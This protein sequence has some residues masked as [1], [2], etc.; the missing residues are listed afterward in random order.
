MSWVWC[1]DK[2]RCALVHAPIRYVRLEGQ[3]EH[4]RPNDLEKLLRP[5]LDRSYF[6]LNLAE[7]AAAAKQHPWVDKVQVERIWPDVIEVKVSEKVPYLRWGERDLFSPQ[8]EKFTPAAYGGAKEDMSSFANLPRLDGPPGH[9][10]LLF[11]A[12]CQMAEAL[13]PLHFKIRKLEVDARR[14]WQLTLESEGQPASDMVIVLGRQKPQ[15]V[16]ARVAQ[17][18]GSLTVR[19]R[20]RIERLDA[21]YKHGFAVRLRQSGSDGK[22]NP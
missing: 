16:F 1:R 5:F 4:V 11:A 6:T 9:E 20:Q 21:R 14:S 18:L 15:E 10:K 13:K 12:Y 2:A 17:F 19:Q 3:L 7:L 22:R 8:G